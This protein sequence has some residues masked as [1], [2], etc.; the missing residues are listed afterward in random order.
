[1]PA[2]SC[3]T[4]LSR[5][6]VLASSHTD[7]VA[8][9]AM[10][11]HVARSRLPRSLDS[12]PDEVLRR[13]F[14]CI[15]LS[16]DV[17][18]P[19]LLIAS[20]THHWREVA[21]KIPSL[22]T[23]VR[24]HHD[25]HISVLGDYLHRSQNLPLSIYIRLKAFR[26]RFVSDYMEALDLLIPHVERWR[27]FS[28]TATNPVLHLLCTRIYPLSLTGLENLE[29]VQSDKGQIQHLGPFIFNPSI[30]RTLRLERTM[31]Y[32]ADASLLSGLTIIDLK[33]SSLAMLDEH[34]LLSIEYPTPE[35][36][37]PSIKALAH[38]EL[39]GSNP[40][41]D[42]GLP[43]SPAFSATH[44]TSLT[45]ARLTA[46]S[47]DRVQALSRFYG[48][49]L[50]GPA[51]RYLAIE[52]IAGHALVMLLSVLRTM[53]FPPLKRFALAGIDTAGI[54]DR[55]M[56]AFT[57]GVEELVLARLDY[58]PLLGRLAVPSLLPDL[59]HI[60]LDGV[61]VSRASVV[62]RFVDK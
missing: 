26:Y 29:L 47:L 59:T 9:E 17:S 23:T 56:A 35:P 40:V 1:M 33:Q 8:L 5:D 50:S 54:D 21:L 58:K 32:P 14:D 53:N 19:E 31:L 42:L 3:G 55:I 2:I 6:W 48:T 4:L 28:V 57:Q 44:L 10:S 39:D 16:T 43:Y 7:S 36:R 12:P 49:A 45:I 18:H 61:R 27:L 51:L 25:R 11:C 46:P 60:E 20:V 38:L 24:I 15:L 30:F 13:I 52:D 41:T 37:R 34:K 62:S 22:W